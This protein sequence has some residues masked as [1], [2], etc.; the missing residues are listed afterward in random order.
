MA[1]SS[2]VSRN[3][4]KAVYLWKKARPVWLQGGRERS[5]ENDV[6]Y[7][8][9]SS[10]SSSSPPLSLTPVGA[11]A[12]YRSSQGIPILGQ[13]LKLSID[14][15]HH[16]CFWFSHHTEYTS[17]QQL[18]HRDNQQCI[19]KHPTTNTSKQYTEYSRICA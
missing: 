9:S 4:Y 18:S 10:S 7:S 14:V 6:Q 12:T 1:I 8:S 3:S 15:T 17:I 2:S 16:F 11:Q 5:I 13:S 19:F